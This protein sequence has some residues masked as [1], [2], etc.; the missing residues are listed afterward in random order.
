[1]PMRLVAAA[2]LAMILAGCAANPWNPTLRNAGTNIYASPDDISEA[3][4]R[5]LPSEQLLPAIRAYTEHGKHSQAQLCVD[6]AI[7]KGWVRKEHRASILAQTLVTGMTNLEAV[8]ALGL[9]NDI[10]RSGTAG[11]GVTQQWIYWVYAA[12]GP[13][14]SRHVYLYVYL[15][16]DVV[17]GWSS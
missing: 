5:S 10:N 12:T 2:A 13:A 15:T 6:V 9:P 17:T 8:A 11:L 14:G 7:E 3:K 16:N 4:A 1:M